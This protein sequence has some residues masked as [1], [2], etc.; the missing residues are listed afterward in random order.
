MIDFLLSLPLWALAIVLNVCL[1]G[2]A[3]TSLWAL[4]RWILPTAA[5]R[6][7]NSRRL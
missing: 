2:F 1:I 3:L 6:Y 7:R 5:H 4:R